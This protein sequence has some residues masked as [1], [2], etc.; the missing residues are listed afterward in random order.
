MTGPK[1]SETRRPTA[2]RLDDSKVHL[3]DDDVAEA[4]KFMVEKSR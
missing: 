2:F 1:P 4:V 3:S